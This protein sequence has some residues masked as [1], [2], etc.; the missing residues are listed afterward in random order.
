M[1]L[2]LNDVDV[3]GIKALDNGH[4]RDVLLR[5]MYKK[6]QGPQHTYK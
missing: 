3:D 1:A 6:A 5:M 2:G 4:A